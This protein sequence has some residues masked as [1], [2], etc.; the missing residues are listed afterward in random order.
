MCDPD[1]VVSKI[2]DTISNFTFGGVTIDHEKLHPLVEEARRSLSSSVVQSEYG[3]LRPKIEVPCMSI[4][5]SSELLPRAIALADRI[6]KT[7]ELVGFT[8]KSQLDDGRP[9]T[10]AGHSGVSFR[11]SV[12]EAIVPTN[13]KK[14]RPIVTAPVID[15]YAR[16]GLLGMNI[17][18]EPY[19]YREFCDTP[20]RPVERHVKEFVRALLYETSRIYSINK[21]KL[22]QDKRIEEE[23]RQREQ[24]ELEKEQIV[25]LENWANVW[26][27]CERMRGFTTAL[28]ARAEEVHGSIAL[29]SELGE[30]IEWANAYIQSF[31]PLNGFAK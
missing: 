28:R 19:I 24:Q 16:T 13:D 29:D 15:G 18:N 23:R 5:V 21:V 10:T 9:L 27:K 7:L 25:Q 4:G 17:D 11:I 22:E 26:H 20:R 1:T 8:I 12:F 3:F 2:E 14:R 6:L 31:D 30:W